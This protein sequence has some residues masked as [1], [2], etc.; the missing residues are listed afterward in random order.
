MS[1]WYSLIVFMVSYKTMSSPRFPV[2]NI[3]LL[4]SVCY[5][6]TM[7]SIIL[8]NKEIIRKVKR[9]THLACFNIYNNGCLY[10]LNILWNSN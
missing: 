5:P 6:G 2:V 7:S 4:T 9:N 3:L 8:F 1:C 10:A